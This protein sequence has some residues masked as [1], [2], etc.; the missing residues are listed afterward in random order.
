[1]KEIYKLDFSI[2]AGKLKKKENNCS[3]RIKIKKIQ[4][5]ESYKIAITS[6]C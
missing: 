1:M 3:N 4:N 2:S 6:R 5:V